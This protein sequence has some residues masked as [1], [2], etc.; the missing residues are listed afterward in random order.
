MLQNRNR[1]ISKDELLDQLWSEDDPQRAVKQLYNGVYYIR[2][3][4]EEYGIGREFISIDSK[5]KLTFGEIYFDIERFNRLTGKIKVLDDDEEKELI[6]LMSGE[7]LEGEYYPWIDFERDRYNRLHENIA[8]ELSKRFISKKQLKLA[9]ELLLKFFNDNKSNEEIVSML[10][11]YYLDSD[12]LS[13]AHGI[14]G[15]YKKSMMEDLG[16][17]P[18][19]G[20]KKLIKY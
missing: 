17:E 20:I 13:K 10:I 2:K 12:N 8:V 14:Y 15:I 11:R 18:S 16:L 7:Y 3:N 1:S 4:L 6:E 19:E 5:Y 9:E